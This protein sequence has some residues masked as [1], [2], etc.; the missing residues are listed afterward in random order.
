ML[1][2]KYDRIHARI[3]ENKNIGSEYV[4]ELIRSEIDQNNL[5]SEPTVLGLATGSSPILIYDILVQF[6]RNNRLSFSNVFTFNL[7]EYYP[8]EP[9]D[10]NSY[11]YYMAEHLFNHVDIDSSHI[12]IPDGTLN[13]NEIE[14]YCESYEEKIA[15]S[16]GIDLQLLGVG[17]NAHIGFNEPGSGI[18]SKTRLVQLDQKTRE[19]AA[20]KFGGLEYTPGYAITMG[21]ETILR[22]KQIVCIAWGSSKAF[23]ISQLFEDKISR[24][25]PITYLKKHSN[26]QL[27]MDQKAASLIDPIFYKTENTPT[28][29]P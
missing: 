23:A 6:H 1:E 29:N 26:V 10:Q 22:S 27:I 21:V 7:D 19:D 16:G 25:Y 20:N 17:S 3:F 8:I 11:H 2:F 12:H 13:R 18:E 5:N 4:S 9:D 15:E 14:S 24:E 28:Y